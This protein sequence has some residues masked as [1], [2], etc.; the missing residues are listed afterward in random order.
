MDENIKTPLCEASSI[1]FKNLSAG[2]DEKY[3]QRF[4]VHLYLRFFYVC[5]AMLF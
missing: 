4:L 2:T 1:N 3:L 5:V